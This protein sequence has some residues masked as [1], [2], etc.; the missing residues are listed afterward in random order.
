MVDRAHFGAVGLGHECHGGPAYWWDDLRRNGCGPT[1][2]DSTPRGVDDLE[3]LVTHI[4]TAN[5]QN[6]T[7]WLEWKIGL[8]LSAAEG[9]FEASK[10]IFGIRQP[11]TYRCPASRR[12]FGVPGTRDRAG[13]SGRAVSDGSGTAD[14]RHS[15]VRW[16]PGRNVDTLVGDV[17]GRRGA[18]HHHRGSPVGRSDSH[19]AERLR[20][21]GTGSDIRPTPGHHQRAMLPTSRC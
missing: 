14:G 17:S 3:Q 19:T 16:D 10:H 13:P 5:P 4:H 1:R 11:V 15:Q 9:R 8:D 12:W 18:R 7:D 2:R 21:D 20:Q 6:E